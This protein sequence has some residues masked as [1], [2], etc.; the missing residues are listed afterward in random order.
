MGERE[1]REALRAAYADDAEPVMGLSAQTVLAAGRRSRRNRRLA[2]FAG[3]G[4][5]AVLAGAGVVAVSGAGSGGA[6]FAAAEPCLI[7]PGSRPSG[8]VA[9]GQALPP[10]VVEWAAVSLTCHLGEEVPR[11]LPNAR[12]AQVPGAPAGP[13]TGFSLGGDRVDAVALVRDAE[14]TGDL[15]VNVAVVDQEAASEGEDQCRREKAAKCTVRPGPRGETVL[16]STEAGG[17][18][19]GEPR[20]YVVRVYRGHSE[21]YV[22]VSNTDRQVKGGGAPVATRPEPVLTADQA[23]QL[24]LSDGLFLFS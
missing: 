14:G 8:V 3:A 19:A 22:Q 11:L 16:L 17:L 7:A 13:L 10:D 6:Q 21:I 1:V 23:V 4:L 12:Y 20:N 15:T 18:P 24:A 2:G 9:A 5:A